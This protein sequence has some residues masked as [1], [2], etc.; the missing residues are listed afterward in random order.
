MNEP[1]AASPSGRLVEAA[2]RS[3]YTLVCKCEW[4]DH[5]YDDV[6]VETSNTC[7]IHGEAPDPLDALLT[8]NK[9]LRD[10]LLDVLVYADD[11][12]TASRRAAIQH[13]REALA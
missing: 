4:E 8:E 3:N 11:G 13:G 9:R 12:D 1:S 7:V 2:I 5:G 10:A 6:I